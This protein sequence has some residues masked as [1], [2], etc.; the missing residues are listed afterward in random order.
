[1]R[2]PKGKGKKGDHTAKVVGE[3]C[4]V[5]ADLV[6][7]VRNG[8]RDNDDVLNI[9]IE[10]QQRHSKLINELK[11]MVPMNAKPRRHAA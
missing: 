10:Y 4:R 1:M 7:K 9:D 8:K 2:K 3:I 5:S 6:R 11:R